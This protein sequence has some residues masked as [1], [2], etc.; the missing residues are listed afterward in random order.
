MSCPLSVGTRIGHVVR[1]IAFLLHRSRFWEIASRKCVK[2][3]FNLFF[4]LHFCPPLNFYCEYERCMNG[5][6]PRGQRAV[7]CVYG[8]RCRIC[9]CSHTQISKH[10]VAARAIH[11]NEDE[12]L[13]LFDSFVIPFA[14]SFVQSFD[15]FLFFFSSWM[16]CGG[17]GVATV[18]GNRISFVACHRR[19]MHK[20]IELYFS[21]S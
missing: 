21:M 7:E 8:C 16:C 2:Y 17:D 11:N 10:I 5:N 6:G 19:R 14:H 20:A 12:C 3:I 18:H 15:G 13:F 4:S 1:G 9:N